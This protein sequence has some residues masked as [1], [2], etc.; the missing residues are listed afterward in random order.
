MEDEGRSGAEVDSNREEFGGLVDLRVLF[1]ALWTANC[2]ERRHGACRH[3]VVDV[4]IAGRSC[5]N[6]ET[7]QAQIPLSAYKAGRRL[8]H[9]HVPGA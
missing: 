6:D 7:K 3:I 5:T 4:L 9:A 2:W 1:H 8:V